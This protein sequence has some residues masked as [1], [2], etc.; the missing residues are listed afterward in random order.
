MGKRK[1][2]FD[3]IGANDVDINSAFGFFLLDLLYHAKKN[4]YFNR[5]QT[6]M[7]KNRIKTFANNIKTHVWALL[8]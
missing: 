1:V 4:I 5:Q 2:N 7:V 3:S 8:E 6:C